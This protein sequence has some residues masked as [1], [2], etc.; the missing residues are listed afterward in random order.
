MDL[1]VV[2]VFFLLVIFKAKTYNNSANPTALSNTKMLYYQFKV[3]W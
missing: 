3:H 1:A 2:I